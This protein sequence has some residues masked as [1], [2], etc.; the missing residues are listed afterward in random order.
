[1]AQDNSAREFVKASLAAMGGEEKFR[2]IKTLSFEA[3]GHTNMIEQSERPEGPWLVSYEQ[4]KES[5]DLENFRLKQ[6]IQSQ[7]SQFSTSLPGRTLIVSNEAA[8][9][10]INGKFV[11]A[12][13]AQIQ[14]SG[15]RLALSPER[16]LLTAL[17]SKELYLERE[18]IMQGVMNHVVSFPWNGGTARIYLNQ[19]TSLPT[20]V[21]TIQAY[22]SGFWAMW[23]DVNTKTFFSYWNLESGG[24]HY[25]RQWDIVRNHQP[26]QTL[27]L[28]NLKFNPDLP[29]DTFSIPEET[30]K[31]Y[32][33]SPKKTIN[34]LKLGLPEQ[35]AAEIAKDFVQIP[36]RWNVAVIKQNDGIV[37]IEAPISSGYSARV[38]ED[39]M[40]RFPNA[41]IK[42][43][44]STAD[45][46]PHFAGLREYAA[47]QI[48]IYLLDL[49]QP[50]V[51]KLIDAPFKIV[52]DALAKN[53]RKPIYKVVKEKTI[54]G[55][56]DNLLELYP[57]R[58]ESGERMIMVYAP[59]YKLLYG[60]DLVQPQSDGT[61]FMP[62]YLSELSAAV[63]REN[64]VVERVFAMHSQVLNW[65][66]ISE[67]VEE[68][69][70]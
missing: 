59:K 27:T 5:R 33:S 16:V 60:S 7:S 21:E 35:P 34:D 26:L 19:N 46:F 14:D 24:I 45:A 23:G 12:A 28:S 67:A 64:I 4:L 22:S 70:K 2:A 63:K 53:F 25:P 32:L 15:E 58:T 17:N 55:D 49:N 61:F 3:F 37:I 10:F 43:V 29:A 42:A 57:I 9:W 51:K 52:P 31:L 6:A 30:K 50:I 65:N 40:R 38:I 18:V 54:V 48:P 56:G 47:R 39:A 36:G 68:A 41:K 11:P 66:R 1:M 8:A 44:I 13:P 69:S 62:Q 20:A